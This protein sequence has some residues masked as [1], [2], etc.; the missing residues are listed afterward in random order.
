MGN[1]SRTQPA[2]AFCLPSKVT[3]TAQLI[4]LFSIAALTTQLVLQQPL[5]VLQQD[6]P[7]SRQQ[8][9]LFAVDTV[10]IGS[11]FV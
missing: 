11:D 8:G 3:P 9:G 2:S 6:I 5:V 1:T 7:L 4:L 10:A